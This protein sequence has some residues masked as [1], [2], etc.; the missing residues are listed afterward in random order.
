MLEFRGAL[1]TLSLFDAEISSNGNGTALI[2]GLK[3]TCFNGD[4]DNAMVDT[5]CIGDPFTVA[6]AA[7]QLIKSCIYS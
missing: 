6:V 7:L 3:E 1:L 4:A 2:E 5:L